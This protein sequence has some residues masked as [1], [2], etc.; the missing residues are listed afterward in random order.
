ML[1]D[2]PPSRG[3]RAGT[4]ALYRLWNRNL[5][6]APN[7]RYT[8]NPFTFGAM[9]GPGW[10]YEGEFPTRVFACVPY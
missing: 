1:P 9:V 5:D 2:A 3:C 7:H 4:R 6:G 10:Q 8:T